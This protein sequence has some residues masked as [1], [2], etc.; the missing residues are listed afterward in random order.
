T[1]SSSDE[2][3]ATVSSSGLVSGIAEG[4]ATITA[5]FG[6]K[7]ATV[8]ITVTKAVNS[9]TMTTAGNV[10]SLTV[11][12]TLQLTTIA[13]N[14]GGSTDV[15]TGSATYAS[16]D[17]S[18]ATV[19][20]VGFVSAVSATATGSP[21]VITAT[22]GGKS[23]SVSLTITAASEG[24]EFLAGST[25]NVR[26]VSDLGNGTSKYK[27]RFAKARVSGDKSVPFYTQYYVNGAS[28]TPQIP[29]ALTTEVTAP[30]GSVWWEFEITVPNVGVQKYIW[31]FGGKYP[32]SWASIAPTA[33]VRSSLYDSNAAGDGIVAEID[34][35]ARTVTKGTME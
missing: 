8:V 20:S 28:M 3:K 25:A 12:M 10:T 18:K 34:V 19:S 33:S 27:V 9:L 14:V 32:S 13:N 30:D 35:T 22:Y 23:A 11:G 24:D 26:Y 1:Y 6:G 5:T 7:T 4:S 15:V 31:N 17:P 29:P 2:S 16:L 21:V